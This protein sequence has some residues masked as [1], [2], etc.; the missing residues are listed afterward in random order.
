M[1]AVTHPEEQTLSVELVI[2]GCA[3]RIRGLGGGSVVHQGY[4]Y[5]VAYL[6][7][8]GRRIFFINE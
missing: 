5:T 6:L 1:R 2:H 7:T 3:G 4:L 8:T